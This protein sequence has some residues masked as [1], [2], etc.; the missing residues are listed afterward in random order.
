[1]TF[2]DTAEAGPPSAGMWIRPVHPTDA[3]AVNELLGQLGYP[4]VDVAATETRILAWSDDP[5]SAAFAAGF[6]DELVGVVAV[7][8]CPFFERDG[9]WARVVALVVS[10]RARGQGVGGKLMSVAE[11]F[12][13][14]RGCARMEVTSSDHREAAHGFYQNRGYINQK[15]RSSRFLNDLAGGE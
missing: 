3:P 14:G 8:V 6:G 1:M 10:D 12:A 2:T 11:S 9:S 7:H 5:S 13:A 4:Q 15:G